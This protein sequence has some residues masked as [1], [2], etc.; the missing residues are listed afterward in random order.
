MQ[1][2]SSV[3][4][5]SS[6]QS[7]PDAER[8]ASL[9]LRTA[10]L[11]HSCWRLPRVTTRMV[12]ANRVRRSSPT[13][14]ESCECVR[15][16]KMTCVRTKGGGG[17]CDYRPSSEIGR[18]LREMGWDAR[19]HRLSLVLIFIILPVAFGVAPAVVEGGRR[20]W[21][22]ERQRVSCRH[23]PQKHVA[24]HARSRVGRGREPTGGAPRVPS[25]STSFRRKSASA[26]SAGSSLL[27]VAGAV[28]ASLGADDVW[29][30]DLWRQSAVCAR[31]ASCGVCGRLGQTDAASRA[32]RGDAGGSQN[33]G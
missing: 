33:G 24:N 23:A 22:Q 29:E 16:Q 19:L 18:M 6:G 20:V 7:G 1:R 31:R 28:A 12:S 4:A 3:F 30:G 17:R 15:L 21:K 9:Q 27:F 32:H 13:A 14:W 11:M 5:V 26:S 25:A 8:S 10:S 2:R